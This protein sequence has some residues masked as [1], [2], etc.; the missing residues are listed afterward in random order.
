ERLLET[1]EHALARRAGRVERAALDER[2]ERPLVH[3][4]RVDALGEVPD[5]RERPALLPRTHDRAAR[6]LADVLHRVQAESDLALDEGVVL[7]RLEVVPELLG[8]TRRNSV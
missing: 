2:L 7:R 1:G 3:D 6:G 4:L 5:R 8:H